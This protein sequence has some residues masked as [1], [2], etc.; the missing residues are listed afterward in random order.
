MCLHRS[1]PSI[2][3]LQLF[4]AA[5]GAA[6][7][8]PILQ[9]TPPDKLQPIPNTPACLTAA[10]QQGDPAKGESVLLIRATGGCHVPWHWH[11][12]NEQLMMVSGTARIEPKGG[13]PVDVRTGG[14]GYAPSKHPH[15]FTCVGR[16]CMFFLR[17]DGVFDVHYVDQNG[18]EIPFEQAIGKTKK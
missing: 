1:I 3:S 6:Q 5:I 10:V 16:P 7:D 2:L 14:F 13:Q 12:P 9:N 18:G 8:R 15:Q 4:V 17:S 11:T